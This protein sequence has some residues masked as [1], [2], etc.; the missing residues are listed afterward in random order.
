MARQCFASCV[1]SSNALKSLIIASGCFPSWRFWGPMNSCFTYDWGLR[2]AVGSAPEGMNFQ[3]A[4]TVLPALGECLDIELSVLE[5]EGATL[6]SDY[7][8]QVV[9]IE[10][11]GVPTVLEVRFMCFFMS[12]GRI[13][14]Q[15]SVSMNLFHP[16]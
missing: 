7:L 9:E 13:Q 8:W 15:G 10:I 6:K 2:G 12:L 3:V 1:L 11:G 5:A 4:A 14:L 16:I